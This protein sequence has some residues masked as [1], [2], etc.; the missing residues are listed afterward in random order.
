MNTMRFAEG[1]SDTTLSAWEEFRRWVLP[2]LSGWPS[3]IE[4]VIDRDE[5]GL[6]PWFLP[7]A[8]GGAVASDLLLQRT[9]YHTGSHRP[10]GWKQ[11]YPDVFVK[12]TASNKLMVRRAKKH[13]WT[14]ER[15]APL[16]VSGD[17]DEVLVHP[18]GSTPILTRNYQSAMRLAEYSYLKPPP[19]HVWVKACPIYPAGAI[20]FAEKRRTDE[21]FARQSAHPAHKQRR[22]A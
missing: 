8:R 1:H 10:P 6:P 16:P 11:L 13:L 20:A 21:A 7:L 14:V 18:F 15:Y 17:W 22:A 19:G 4:E 3:M 5:L 9:G 12:Y 2:S